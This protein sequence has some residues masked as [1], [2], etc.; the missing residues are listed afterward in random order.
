A[1]GDKDPVNGGGALVDLLVAHYR[2]GGLEDVGVRV[3]AGARHEILNETNRAQVR[4][5]ILDWLAE[6]VEQ[7]E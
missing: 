6:V 1:V 3:F 7:G 4:G 5:E 2:N